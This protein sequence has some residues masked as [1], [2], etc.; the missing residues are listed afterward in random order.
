MED[1]CYLLKGKEKNH[2]MKTLLFIAVFAL[3]ISCGNKSKLKDSSNSSD[4][5]NTESTSIQTNYPTDSLHGE[6]IGG[7]GNNTIIITVNHIN[8]KNCSGYNI[9]KG[10]RRNIKGE[11]S[12]Q[13]AYFR[14][15]LSEPGGDPNDGNF[16]F[17]IDTATR[18]ME[19]TWSPYDP[20]NKSRKY[21]LTRRK[22]YSHQEMA[23]YI[24]FWHLNGLHVEF[25]EDESGVAIGAW[26]NAELETSEDVKI[27]FTWFENNDMVSI[28][29]GKNDIFSSPKMK[30]QYKEVEHEEMLIS[31]DYYMHRL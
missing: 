16:R 4:S 8:G 20:K 26:W 12:N 13:G 22:Y 25:K 17:T 14:F 23:G 15:D 19:G 24:G 31:G 18:T 6:Y 28:E 9:L 1:R 29:W 2:H 10:T 5:T 3:L 27:P 21:K 11:V 30:F 7:F